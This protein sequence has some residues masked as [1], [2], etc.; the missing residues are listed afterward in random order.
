[1]LIFFNKISHK[2]TLNA[3]RRLSCDKFEILGT[4]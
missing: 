1:M 4:S 2:N 3:A